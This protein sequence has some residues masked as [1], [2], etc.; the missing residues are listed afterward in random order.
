MPML[1]ISRR[2]FLETAAVAAAATP[3]FLGANRSPFASAQGNGY[4]PPQ[5][6]RTTLNFNLNWQFIRQDVPGAE[7]PAFDDSKWSTVSTPHSFND[8]DSFRKIIS[9]SGGDLGTYKGLSW[10]RKHF[11]IPAELAGHKIFLEFEGMRQAGDI[12]L[13][14]KVVGL[15]ENGITAY[16]LDISDAVHCG[17]LENV[18]AVKLDNTTTYEEC[19]RFQSRSWRHQQACLAARC[20]QHLPDSSALLRTGDNRRL[21]ARRQL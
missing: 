7:A 9:H 14:G 13:N 4:M 16:G 11:K 6:P 12:F 21:R 3:V 19:K 10:Y 1:R 5:S 2:Q 15:Y 18:L 8:V 17:P 20:G